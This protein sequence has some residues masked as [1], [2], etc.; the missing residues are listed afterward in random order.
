MLSTQ[1]RLRLEEICD[2]I[3]TG[4]PVSLEEIKYIQ[5]WA[6]HNRT[7]ATLLSQARRIAAQG[8]PEHGS[9]DQLL[10]DLDL[11]DPD[12]SNHL[13]GPIDPTDL[14]AWFSRDQR[15]DWR[16]RD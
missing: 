10:N 7:A 14:S 15:E 13:S 8:N 3:K 12:P 4:R 11:G 5:K 2:R 1:T 6:D 16:Q 9:L